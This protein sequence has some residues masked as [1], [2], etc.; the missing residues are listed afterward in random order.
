MDR[1]DQGSLL[2]FGTDFLESWLKAGRE[3]ENSS[4]NSI[5]IPHEWSRPYKEEV[6]MQFKD[7]S[8]KMGMVESSSMWKG[9]TEPKAA[10]VQGEM[11]MV[12][13][14]GTQ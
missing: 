12:S 9:G 8:Y 3:R 6:S 11:L 14:T 7:I 2:N 10:R 4:L 13:L 5:H 1:G